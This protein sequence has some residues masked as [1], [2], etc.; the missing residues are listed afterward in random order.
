MLRPLCPVAL[1]ALFWAPLPVIA[2][3]PKD[4]GRDLMERGLELFFEGLKGEMD[5][6]LKDLESFIAGAGPAMQSFLE[7]MGPA[8]RDLMAEVKDW[9]V[10]EPPV[11]LPNGDILIRRKPKAAP[12]LREGIGVG[13]QGE[14][15]L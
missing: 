1:V 13:P 9:S 14:V 12:P 5:P 8:L 11:V 6:V 10:Y 15:D 7:E 2:E 4:G 3:A